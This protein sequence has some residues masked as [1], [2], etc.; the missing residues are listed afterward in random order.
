MAKKEYDE[1]LNKYAANAERL[2][3]IS[4][5][6]FGFSPGY[7]CTIKG[8]RD[9][10]EICDKLTEI[11]CDLIKKVYP[12]TEDDIAMIEAYKKGCI[13]TK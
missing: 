10:V 6:H 5:H 4:I 2:H 1:Y 12:E 8:K 9:S 13:S 11:I 3:R 7:L